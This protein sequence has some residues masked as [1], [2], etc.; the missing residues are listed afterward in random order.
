MN[1]TLEPYFEFQAKSF[2]LKRKL[3][4]KERESCEMV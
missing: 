3:F 2:K 1:T 4:N